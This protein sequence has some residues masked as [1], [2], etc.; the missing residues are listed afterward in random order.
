MAYRTG[1]CAGYR[2][3]EDETATGGAASSS[4]MLPVPAPQVN[5]PVVP[6]GLPT[7]IRTA[8]R[9]GEVRVNLPRLRTVTA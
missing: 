5:H 6:P 7:R 2:Q 4:T 1:M 9:T 8:C 3:I